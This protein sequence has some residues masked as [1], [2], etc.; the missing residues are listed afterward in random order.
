ML[1]TM[2]RAVNVWRFGGRALAGRQSNAAQIHSYTTTTNP[3]K[4]MK[5]GWISIVGL[6]SHIYI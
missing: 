6:V 1:D 4:S 3:L 2:M 5:K